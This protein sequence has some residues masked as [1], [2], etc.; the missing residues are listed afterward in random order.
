MYVVKK[1]HFINDFTP[2]KKGLYTKLTN[3]REKTHFTIMFIYI[4]VIS[5]VH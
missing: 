5:C 4:L 2:E 3:V 1:Y